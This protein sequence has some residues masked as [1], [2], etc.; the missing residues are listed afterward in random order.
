MG[1]D[2]NTP[3]GRDVIWRSRALKTPSYLVKIIK[4]SSVSETEKPRYIRA[5]DFLKGPEEAQALINLLTS[6]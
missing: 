2:W 4:S 5:L 1:N 6:N 3:G